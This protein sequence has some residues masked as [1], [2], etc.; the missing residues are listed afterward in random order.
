M[1]S[2]DLKTINVQSLRAQI[3]IVS[4][5]PVLFDRTIHENIAYGDNSRDVPMDEIIA[6]A[7]NANIHEFIASLPDVGDTVENIFFLTFLVILTK[8][9]FTG[10]SRNFC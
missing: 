10:L 3:G 9:T 8:L 5:E 2:F 6:A 7:R 4:Q 1:D